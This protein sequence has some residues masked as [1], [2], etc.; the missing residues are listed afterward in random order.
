MSQTCGHGDRVTRKC[1]GLVHR[2]G[3]GNILHDFFLATE[4]TNRHTAADHLTQSGQIRCHAIVAL[5]TALG[6]AEAS[7]HFVDDQQGAELIAKFTQ[8][9]KE[10]CNRRD[11]VHVAGNRLEY[12][13]G[14]ILRMLAEQ[15]FD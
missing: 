12:D 4:G 3:R 8:S 7:H 15:L 5:G 6:D 13:T 2:A 9:F 1:A 10:T 14:D 11:T